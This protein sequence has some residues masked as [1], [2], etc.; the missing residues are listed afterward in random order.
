MS[1]DAF[2]IRSAAAN[3]E[4][5][6]SFMLFDGACSKAVTVSKTSPQNHSSRKNNMSRYLLAVMGVIAVSACTDNHPRDAASQSPDST[7]RSE[8]NRNNTDGSSNGRATDP[9]MGRQ[10]R[11]GQVDGPGLNDVGSNTR[12]T[13][14]TAVS[15]PAAGR[16]DRKESALTA[17]DQSESE[18]DR[19]ITQLVRQAVVADPMMS[20]R[21]KNC[22][23]ITIGG[24]VTLRGSVDTAAERT[25]LGGKADGI[26]GVRRVDN[27]LEIKQ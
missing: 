16:G 26:S 27:Q 18:G 3:G 17:G 11:T 8:M 5:R 6:D 24:V 10:S 21:A 14:R 4:W 25:L 9:S 7:P 12:S 23:I 22:T 2:P 1:K 15:P 13:D 19:R 20:M